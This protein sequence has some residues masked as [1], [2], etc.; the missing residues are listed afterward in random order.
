MGFDRAAW[1]I[2]DAVHPFAVSLAPSDVRITTRWDETYFPSSLYGAMHECGH[3]LYEAGVATSL[4]RTPLAQTDS[5]GLHE[6]QSRMWENMVG[7]GRPFAEVLSPLLARVPSGADRA[8]P[9]VHGGQPGASRRSSGSRPTRRPT[10]CTSSSASRLEQD[11]V[12]GRLS[13]ADLPGGVERALPR[14]LWPRGARRRPGVLQDV[15]WSIGAIGYFPTYA[16]GN[17]IAGQ[18]WEKA[19]I[20][21]PDLEERIAAGELMPLRE[22]LRE[23]V[24]RHGAKFNCDELLERVVG[25]PIVVGPFLELPEGQAR[26]TSTG[27]S[28]RAAAGLQRAARGRPRAT[29]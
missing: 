4:H 15:H 18:L 17:L 19:N 20:D 1:R 21:I 27:S 7:R 8:R 26:A 14:E 9:A 29:R 6:S 2:D 13:V 24:H 25:G 12:A 10:A 5:L 28:C 3:G 16:L 22:W 23:N 11:L